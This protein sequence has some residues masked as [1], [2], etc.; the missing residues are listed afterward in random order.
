M[1][2]IAYLN[3]QWMKIAEA[4]V[5]AEDRGYNF[6][7][8]LYEV[9]V[10]YGGRIWA[11]ER[12]LLRLER[13]IHE[14]EFEGVDI[15][16]IRDVLKEARERSGISNAF[17]YLQLTR[18][19]APRKH[20]WPDTI[21]PS[22]FVSVRPIPDHDPAMWTEGVSMVTTADIRWGRCDIKTTNLLPNCLAQHRA[23]KAG[24][25]DT[26]LVREG[27]IVTECSAFSL[28]IVKDVTLITREAG[29][30][31]LPSITQGLIV[32][33]AARV[34]IPVA[35]RPFTKAQLLGADEAFFAVTSMGAVPITRID[36]R[37]VGTGMPGEVTKRL[38]A[39][40]L[41]RRERGDDAVAP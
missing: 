6:G 28:F 7:D 38:L 21:K 10:S 11:L 37:P 30:H 33:T 3:G 26:I 34:G 40:Y 24:F 35:R 41:E 17:I 25:F 18:G 15:A 39:A 5:P 32:E 23:H 27:G 19:V 36:E 9:L 13:G 31:I 2:E 12:H 4:M 1:G 8:A 20:D 22:L 14:L 29:P 16:E